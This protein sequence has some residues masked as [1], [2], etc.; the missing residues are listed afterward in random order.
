MKVDHEKGHEVTLKHFKKIIV[1]QTT[2][3]NPSAIKLDIN[4]LVYK[5]LQ[6][7][8]LFW[9]SKKEILLNN[10]WIKEI[11]IEIIKDLELNANR[12][13]THQNMMTQSTPYIER[14]L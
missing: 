11:I 3:C 8:P 5:K 7:S 14:S 1:I 9:K 10:S 12:T 13:I 2:L 6:P 4:N